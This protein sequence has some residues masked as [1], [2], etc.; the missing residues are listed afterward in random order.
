[1]RAIGACRHDAL[2]FVAMFSVRIRV[3]FGVI[4]ALFIA[5]ISSTAALADGPWPNDPQGPQARSVSD[6]YWI[7][8]VAAVVV[9]A[10]V[11]GGIIYA[12]IKFRERPGHVAKQ[13]HGHNLLELTWTI[14]PTVMVLGFSVLSF[15]KLLYINDASTDAQMTVKVVAQQWVWNFQYPSEP[16]F[17]TTDG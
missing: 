15:Q 16:A 3:A 13:F 6:L 2:I 5:L 14:I 17:K 1:M 12:G 11:D 4:T 7:M 8:F 9:L 10:I